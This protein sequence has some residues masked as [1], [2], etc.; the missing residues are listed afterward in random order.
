MTGD[1][2]SGYSTVAVSLRFASGAV[3]TLLGSYDSSYSYPRTSQVEINGSA[4]RALIDDTVQRYTFSRTG[5]PVRQ[6]WEAGYF[7]D[8]GRSFE[9]T[10]DAHL[11]RLLPALQAGEP[12]P[13]PASAGLRALVVGQA[14][15][16][17]FQT[18]QRTAVPEIAATPRN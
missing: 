1:P 18:G 7:D 2:T 8:S 14:V 15:I 5:D 12:P 3:G 6:V 11:D 10:F 17:A 16:E 13:V 9:R 4:G